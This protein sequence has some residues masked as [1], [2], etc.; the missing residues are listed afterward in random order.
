MWAI[1]NL[2]YYCVLGS[3]E[4]IYFVFRNAITIPLTPTCIF[5]ICISSYYFVSF[6]SEISCIPFW[7]EFRDFQCQLIWFMRDGSLSPHPYNLLEF[8]AHSP[9]VP[10]DSRLDLLTNLNQ[11]VYYYSQSFCRYLHVPNFIK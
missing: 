6:W 11:M 2:I 5:Q 8:G 9:S 3:S 1:N 4:Y 10:V 7:V